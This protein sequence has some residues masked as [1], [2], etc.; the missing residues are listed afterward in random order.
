MDFFSVDICKITSVDAFNKHFLR[1]RHTPRTVLDTA[2]AIDD[3]QEC[4]W[5][6]GTLKGTRPRKGATFKGR[7][8]ISVHSTNISKKGGTEYHMTRDRGTPNQRENMMQFL[9]SHF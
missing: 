4:S 9:E 1:P 6:G 5:R 7:K 2:G 3:G 8:D